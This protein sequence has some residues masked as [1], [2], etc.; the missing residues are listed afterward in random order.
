MRDCR[1]SGGRGWTHTLGG[2]E[3]VHGLRGDGTGSTRRHQESAPL[4]P[5]TQNQSHS[6]TPES[7]HQDP[8]K[9]DPLFSSHPLKFFCPHRPFTTHHYFPPTPTFPSMQPITPFL[10]TSPIHP[11]VP[12][13]PSDPIATEGSCFITVRGRCH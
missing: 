3:K 2:Y 4:D 11:L 1:G 6:L 5:L 7:L 12:L 9:P 10:I 8:F 13:P